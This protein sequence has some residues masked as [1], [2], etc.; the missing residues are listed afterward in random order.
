[1]NHALDLCSEIGLPI[2]GGVPV[3]IETNDRCYF[4]P[5]LQAWSEGHS[6]VDPGS[7]RRHVD[8]GIRPSNPSFRKVESLSCAAASPGRVLLGHKIIAFILFKQCFHIVNTIVS[9]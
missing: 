2:G 7:C 8:L 4:R 5:D 6:L 3:A 1:M 9:Y